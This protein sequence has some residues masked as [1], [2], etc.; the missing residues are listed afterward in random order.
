MKNKFS[1]A[2]GFQVGCAKCGQGGE[3]VVIENADRFLVSFVL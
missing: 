3:K 1:E 2:L